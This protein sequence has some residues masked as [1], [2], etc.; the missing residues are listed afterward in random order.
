MKNGTL[1]A[2]ISTSAEL[3]AL[4][5]RE[6]NMNQ[7]S[8]FWK[9]VSAVATNLFTEGA[10]RDEL[11]DLGNKIGAAFNYHPGEFLDMYV[12]RRN[13]D[14]QRAAN[15]DFDKLKERMLSLAGEVIDLGEAL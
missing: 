14:E 1:Q 11:V 6:I 2:V 15:D 12:I 13:P 3:A 7:F 9:Q 4:C 5:A 8:G 10:R